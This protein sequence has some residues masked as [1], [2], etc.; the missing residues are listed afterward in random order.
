MRHV[1]PLWLR[2]KGGVNANQGV[3]QETCQET[4]GE[5]LSRPL[6]SKRRMSFFT[7]YKRKSSHGALVDGI[8]QGKRQTVVSGD[9]RAADTLSALESGPRH[10]QAERMKIDSEILRWS[11]ACNCSQWQCDHLEGLLVLSALWSGPSPPLLKQAV[12]V[13]SY[14]R[15]DLPHRI[16]VF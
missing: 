11:T 16:R 8:D 7:V 9:L 13:F 12:A 10:V 6:S 3:S 4:S 2:D 14:Q 5:T 15:D 1:S